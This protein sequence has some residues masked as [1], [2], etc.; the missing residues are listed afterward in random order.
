VRFFA[1]DSTYLTREQTRWLDEQLQA[2]SAA[3]KIAFFHHPLYSSGPEDANADLRSTLEPLFVR[4]NVSVAL[5]GQDH[6]YER[7]KAQQGITHFVVGSSGKLGPGHLNGA[8]TLTAKGFDTDQAFLAAE[9][10]GDQMFF[11]AVSRTGATVDS[12]VLRRRSSK[13]P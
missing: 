1:L 2:S 7:L 5:A 6:F 4:Y 12:G 8:S 11:A 10:M 9:I 3:W 13:A